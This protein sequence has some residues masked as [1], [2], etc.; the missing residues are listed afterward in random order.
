L[1]PDAEIITP[2]GT[3]TGSEF[4]QGMRDWGGLDSLDISV[5]DRVISQESELIVS[6]ATRVFRW[7]ESGEVAYEQ[8]AE[9]K[10]IVDAGTITHVD[11]R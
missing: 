9:V 7:K 4:L 2:D 3:V 6:R 5:R 10:L 1:A 8:P 11:M